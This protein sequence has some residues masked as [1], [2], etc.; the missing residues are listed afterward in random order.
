MYL[1]YGGSLS[2]GHVRH[3]GLRGRD[4]HRRRGLDST[5]GTGS[6][7][8]AD[9]DGDGYDDLVP[10]AYLASVSGYYNNGV[11]YVF[12]GP[13]SGDIGTSAYT[14]A[15]AGGVN[16]E[17]SGQM[18]AA[19]DFNDDGKSDILVNATNH[20]T[21]GCSYCGGAYLALGGVTGAQVLSDAF[22]TLLGPTMYSSAGTASR[23]STT[24][25]ATAA[26]RWPSARPT[27]LRSMTG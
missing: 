8:A 16:Y 5:S 15:L 22:A 13:I 27:T 19:G 14:A 24:G 23:S 21:V 4:R 17:Y 26:T 20:T 6:S 1:S 9:Y 2:P 3:R 11:T 7:N 12:A 25:T 18:L 10:S